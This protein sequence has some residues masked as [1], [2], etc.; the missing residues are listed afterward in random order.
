[1]RTRSTLPALLPTREH[2][3]LTPEAL[4]LIGRLVPPLLAPRARLLGYRDRVRTRMAEGLL[5]RLADTAHVR[6]A[7]WTVDPVPPAL[8]E[9][10]VELVG[11]C[12]RAELVRGMNAGAKSYVADLQGLAPGDS[13]RAHGRLARAARRKLTFVDTEGEATRIRPGTDTRLLVALRPLTATDE[14]VLLDGE[15]VP[16]GFLDLCLLLQGSAHDLLRR[17][18]GVYVVLRGVHGHLEARL[19]KTLF[20]EAEEALGL[21]RGTI[22]A[23]VVVDNVACALEADE[24]LFELMHHSA[25]L[26]VD[27]AGYVADHLALFSGPERRPLPDREHI[28]E[29]A[30]LLRALMQDLLRVAHRREAHLLGAPAW[31]LPPA[32]SLRTRRHY[33]ALL[34]RI[35]AQ[36]ALGLD[37]T[38]VGHPGLVGAALVEFNKHMPKAHQ[39]YVRPEGEAPVATLVERPEGPITV[40]GLLGLVRTALRALAA[41][42]HHVT[43]GGRL[44]DRTSARLAVL[45]LWQWQ[46]SEHGTITASGLEV[47]DDL[48][49]Y[50]VKKEA[51]KL[52]GDHEAVCDK[53][54]AGLLAPELPGL[55]A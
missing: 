32:E 40:D 44:H 48:L 2:A 8:L 41:D 7:E 46:H 34:E 28:G 54:L 27:P 1:M 39:F 11:G 33:P 23:T 29:D 21:D 3:A 50:L 53:L 24:V 6:E 45:L 38:W 52:G 49:K 31:E 14:T 10:R 9:R 36:A 18:Q 30:P 20:D 5:G 19:W 22:R 55:F 13:L 47:H 17:Q 25:G 35:E 51:V 15:P 12:S 4:R 16:A 26:A 43:E 42:A 37:G